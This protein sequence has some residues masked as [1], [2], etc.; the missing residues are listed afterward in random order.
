MGTA[1]VRHPGPGAGRRADHHRPGRDQPGHADLLGSS[2]FDSWENEETFVHRDPL[3]NPVHKN[4]PWNKVTLPKP[5]KRD[6]AD[7]YSWVVS[8]RMYDKRTG[9]HVASDTGGGPSPASG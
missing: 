9:R 1:P 5:Q 3:G 4:H 7:K 2:Y 8:P 6:W